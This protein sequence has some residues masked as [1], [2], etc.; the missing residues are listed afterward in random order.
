MATIKFS[1]FNAGNINVAGAQLVGLTGGNTATNARFTAADLVNG[2]ATV[3]YVDSQDAGL[4]SQITQN[5]NNIANID[6]SGLQSNVS[7]LQGQVS[8]LQGNIVVLDSAV[9][10]LENNV[11]VNQDDIAVLQGNVIQIENDLANINTDSQTLAWDGAN[12]NLAISNGNNVV[13]QEV[14]DNAGNITV[15]QGQIAD[16]QANGNIQTISLDNSSNVLTISGGNSV[17]FTTVLGNVA[18]G[19]GGGLPA[20]VNIATEDITL[21]VTSNADLANLQNVIAE[22]RL[23]SS[24]DQDGSRAHAP[25]IYVDISPGNYEYNGYFSIEHMVPNVRFRSNGGDATDTIIVFN[26]QVNIIDSTVRFDGVDVNF[27]WQLNVT[28]DSWVGLGMSTQMKFE[29]DY[30]TIYRGSRVESK[31]CEFRYTY[32]ELSQNSL[33]WSSGNSNWAGTASDWWLLDTSKVHLEG[34]GGTNLFDF[35]DVYS[36]MHS[37][38]YAR[39]V[40]G[41]TVSTNDIMVDDQSQAYIRSSA[42]NIDCARIDLFDTSDLH[43]EATNVNTSS[44]VTLRYVSR[45]S[46]TGAINVTGE[47][48]VLETSTFTA[49]NLTI[50][51][52]DNLNIYAGSKV[53]IEDR[54]IAPFIDM[55]GGTLIAAGD[56]SSS[57]GDIYTRSLTADFGSYVAAKNEIREST[58]VTTTEINMIDSKLVAN[59]ILNCG[60]CNLFSSDLRSEDG[61]QFSETNGVMQAYGSI[62]AME[63]PISQVGDTAGNNGITLSGSDLLI[64]GFDSGAAIKTTYMDLTGSR[65]KVLSDIELCRDRD[66][67][68]ALNLREASE[69]SCNRLKKENAFYTNNTLD[70][71]ATQSSRVHFTNLGDTTTD[72]LNLTANVTLSAGSRFFVTENSTANNIGNSNIVVQTF[73]EFFSPLGRVSDYL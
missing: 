72:G 37:S 15:M 43:L 40:G 60:Q 69:V 18:G 21:T 59:R 46:V 12:A 61:I 55:Q 63:G 65:V 41:T 2:L 56:T 23:T 62:I 51:G 8:V 30:F 31:N 73:S 38:F 19:G 16:L 53:A 44:G 57:D 25:I 50:A 5:A 34:S 26:D 9:A 28:D 6:L 35:Y 49:D 45:L 3:T 58:G 14:L 20:N 54:C 33:F 52:T 11:S 71:I 17:D 7:T 66:T 1:E 64:G 67:G 70:L 47:V 48:N 10:A 22:Y 27:P 32:F 39:H 29:S 24:L 13:L 68:V 42:G 4:Q 36:A